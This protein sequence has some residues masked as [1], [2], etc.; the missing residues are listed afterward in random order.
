MYD[1]PV[2]TDVDVFKTVQK[3]IAS[4]IQYLYKF[5]QFWGMFLIFID[6]PVLICVVFQSIE[7][8]KSHHILIMGD[9]R[10]QSY[11]VSS[12][13][14]DDE[15][16]M[17]EGDDGVKLKKNITLINGV[18]IIVG[19]II[20]SGIFLTPKGVMENAGSVSSLGLNTLVLCCP[21]CNGKY[22]EHLERRRF[23]LVHNL[24]FPLYTILELIGNI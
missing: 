5:S 2:T 15:P 22:S 7:C 12:M 13:P 4:D 23:S 20:G 14:A 9:K 11:E 1:G 21:K 17:T 16:V 6:A 19:C 18:A 24:D 10:K 3:D 8:S